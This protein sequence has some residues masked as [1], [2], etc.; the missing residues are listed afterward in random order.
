MQAPREPHLSSWFWHKLLKK[1]GSDLDRRSQSRQ[2]LG[3]VQTPTFVAES[4]YYGA[5]CA[6][7]FPQYELLHS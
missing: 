7:N 3:P 1:M 2:D 4:N 5:V 6:K